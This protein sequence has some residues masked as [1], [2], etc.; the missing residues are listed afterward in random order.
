MNHMWFLLEIVDRVQ[1][2][3]IVHKGLID[4]AIDRVQILPFRVLAI[5]RVH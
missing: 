1:I 5:D 4:V 2:L 3:S